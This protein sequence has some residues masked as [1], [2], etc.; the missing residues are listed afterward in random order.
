MSACIACGREL[1]DPASIR[2]GV[3]PICATKLERKQRG[4][5]RPW[6]RP[7][8]RFEKVGQGAHAILII[9]D[10]SNSHG[11]PSVTNAVEEV[12]QSIADDL[13]ALPSMIIYRDSLGTWDRIRATSRGA[14]LGFDPIG[15]RGYSSA[16]TQA[17][18]ILARETT[19]NASKGDYKP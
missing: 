18:R 6:A 1:T 19:L 11:G 8:F 12:L 15:A 2:V 16:L 4:E 13:G 9:E 10:Q 5:L 14:F 7:S 3:G 17:S